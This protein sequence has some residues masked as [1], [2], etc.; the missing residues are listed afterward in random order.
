MDI[1]ADDHSEERIPFLGMDPHAVQMIIVKYPVIY[2]FTGSTVVV[3]LLIFLGASG[4]RGIEPDIPVGFCV[5]AAAIGGW[6][7]F[8][9]AMAGIG[10][11][12]GKGTAPFAGM[13]L[14]TI[15]PVDHAQAC[16]T[17]GSAVF[18]NG[19]RI[20]DRRGPAAIFIEVNK[21]ADL[22]L[23]AE[24]VGG[25]VVMGRVQTEVTDGDVWVQGL[26]FTQG[27]D[28]ADAVMPPGVEEADMQ[29][30]VNSN[31]RVMGAEHVEGVPKIEG[32]HV[33]V[34]SPIRV[35]VRKM[36]FTG[37]MGNVVFFTFTNLASIGRG[38]GMDTGAIA[39]ECDAI[40]RDESI[41]PGRDEGGQ[42][43]DPLEP[44][45]IMERE[46]FMCQGMISHEVSDP[47]MFIGKLFSFAGLFGRLGVFI[48]WKE[49]FPA[50]FLGSFWLCPEPVHK[51]KIRAE[52][53]QGIRVTADQHGKKGVCLQFLYPEGK[54]GKAKHDHKDK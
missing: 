46:I 34:P 39:G 13:L 44:F 25:I 8:L 47:V 32:I 20:R 36:P 45:F 41:L 52:R 54:A 50:G 51:V 9:F 16:H 7:A 22:P 31:L 48:F 21:R 14:F 18:V 40:L 1:N 12:A 27:D 24:P 33:A 15:A 42:P 28:G 6:G 30:K 29:G 3:N 49:V 35:R 4:H 23:L 11:A 26:E 17:Q 38:M 37:A 2:P 53:G 5:D 19:D 43:E 10:L